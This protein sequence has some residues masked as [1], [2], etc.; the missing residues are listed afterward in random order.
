MPP[1]LARRIK[2][3]QDPDFNHSP[4]MSVQTVVLWL[5][6]AVVAAFI[7]WVLIGG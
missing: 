2:W 1:I 7:V 3:Y 4:A 5:L 6:I